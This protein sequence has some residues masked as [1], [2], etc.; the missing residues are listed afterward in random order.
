[1]ALADYYEEAEALDTFSWVAMPDKIRDAKLAHM[2]IKEERLI[3]SRSR[4]Y[5]GPTTGTVKLFVRSLYSPPRGAIGSTVANVM[6]EI[7]RQKAIRK[8]RME[9]RPYKWK[10][11]CKSVRKNAMAANYYTIWGTNHRKEKEEKSRCCVAVG[12]IGGTLLL[13][14]KGGYST[15]LPRIY[16]RSPSGKV[17]VVVVE[18][19]QLKSMTSALTRLAPKR[20]LRS[21]F[22]GE[23][24]KLNADDC[25]FEMGGK[26]YPWRNVR[27]IYKGQSRA[28]QTQSRPK[29][30]D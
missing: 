12:R 7:E 28:H 11:L 9:N 22:D 23:K 15:P 24:V 2:Y 6:A 14:D 4:N 17:R 29:K 19:D 1:M 27:R 3:R 16:M 20:V 13:V 21:I 26:F 10:K 25:G 18:G 8:R 5:A 30:E